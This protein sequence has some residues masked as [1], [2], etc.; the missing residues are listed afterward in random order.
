[1]TLTMTSRIVL[2]T[3]DNREEESAVVRHLQTH[4]APSGCAAA[5]VPRP[6]AAALSRI[7]TA[8]GM[9]SQSIPFG[10]HTTLAGSRGGN[11]TAIMTIGKIDPW[12]AE[13]AQAVC[14]GMIAPADDAPPSAALILFDGAATVALF[15]CLDALAA[16]NVPFGI[17]TVDGT[18]A[19]RLALLKA[20]LFDAVEVDDVDTLETLSSTPA[21]AQRLLVVSGHG[22]AVDV[23][24]VTA[25]VLC[26]RTTQSGAD[27]A[28][29]PCFHDGQCFR[30]P[31][32]E[33][34]P[35][36]TQGLF[37]A[38]SI[39][40]PIVLLL[41]CATMPL[42]GAPAY[43]ST[44]VGGLRDSA[45][46]GGVAANGILY[47]DAAVE[48]LL[49]ALLLDGCTLGA[50]VQRF[51]S[52]HRDL[53]GHTS[54][55]GAGYGPLMAFGHPGLRVRR[56]F[57]RAAKRHDGAIHAGGPIRTT[58]NGRALLKLTDISRSDA[59]TFCLDMVDGAKVHAA[60]VDAEG[61]VTTY[62]SLIAPKEAE[63]LDEPL[64]LHDLEHD[65]LRA[66]V[67]ML[68]DS[69]P[70]FPFWR[71]FLGHFIQRAQIDERLL[72]ALR[73]REE[74]EM[75][76][77]HYLSGNPFEGEGLVLGVERLLLHHGVVATWRRW[78]RLM[79]DA[80][81]RHVRQSG[82]FTFHAWQDVYRRLRE[83][84]RLRSCPT[85]AQP[86]EAIGYVSQSG[87]PADAHDLIQC[88]SCGVLGELPRGIGMTIHT[89]RALRRGEVLPLS[90]DITNE[91]AVPVEAHV[92][93]IREC[94]FQQSPDVSEAVEVVLEAGE[95][96]NV[97]L[98]IGISPLLPDG[99]Y[100]LTIA[101]VANGGL[102]H[103][104]HHVPT[105]GIA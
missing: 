11:T 105:G 53:F 55:A 18:Q 86:T 66:E 12:L 93:A 7:A 99:L 31:L 60:Q 44:I 56:S 98:T 52:W 57:V 34:A 82:G 81:S 63:L 50:A 30:Q 3:T 68:R 47:H 35:A 80:T 19:G 1:M 94:W 21:D 16:R 45:A 46:L 5:P 17:V 24:S 26:S 92:L 88:L 85:C 58:R 73:V 97:P 39:A 87:S 67:A 4:G 71:T 43:A 72:E 96:R 64:R 41:G 27:P 37:D 54:A 104:R 10:A 61:V 15:R 13:L 78:Q 32:F 100:P 59:S 83:E 14:G 95:T 84:P 20:L 36:S 74:A 42:G 75:S 76:L 28:A 77:L 79:L 40:H 29:Y 65:A 62:V 89:P 70:M 91:R 102:I 48:S 9:P 33:R 103:L 22:N 38:T 51:N 69:A 8:H 2:V 90:I 23:G 49:L 101:G 25:G 6:L